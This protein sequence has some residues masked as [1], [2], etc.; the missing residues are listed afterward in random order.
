M[1]GCVLAGAVEKKS[2]DGDYYWRDYT[3]DIPQ[4]AVEGG[5]DI[6]KRTTY[7][8]QVY[9]KNGGIIPVTIYPGQK[10]VMANIFTLHKTQD[11]IKILCS[12]S[13]DNFKWVSANAKDIHLRFIGKHLVRG[14]VEY[15]LVSN[16]GRVLYQNEI[17]V[18][19]VC[20]FS[21]GNAN[22]Y[23]PYKN[24]EKSSSLYEVLVYE[25]K[26]TTV[27]TER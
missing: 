13:K 8:G 9:V 25:P 14:G 18:G 17:V 5:S 2:G 21:V 20:G 10:F 19:K 3:G 27:G 7:I 24:E 6:N 23:F 15:G 1:S 16:I 4:D 26:T 11:Y 22:M 12:S